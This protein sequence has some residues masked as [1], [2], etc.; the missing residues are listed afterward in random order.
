M[1]G[2][3]FGVAELRVS[4]AWLFDR[5]FSRISRPPH[6]LARIYIADIKSDTILYTIR[7]PPF[8]IHSYPVD[9]IQRV[10]LTVLS[11]RLCV[12]SYRYLRESVGC[13]VVWLLVQSL[14]APITTLV[15]TYI[16]VRTDT[17][18]HAIR[19]PPSNLHS[20]PV[21]SIQ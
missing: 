10:K 3:R 20:Y 5:S 13:L 18:L 19:P 2:P 6:S 15:R 11:A 12:L 1:Q 17:F 14:K 16:E 7:L 9:S 8:N 4:G 21:D